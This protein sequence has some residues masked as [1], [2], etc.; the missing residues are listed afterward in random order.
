MKVKSKRPNTLLFALIFI[1]LQ[2]L[3]L[4]HGFDCIEAAESTI[5]NDD[6]ILELL[7]QQQDPSVSIECL[8]SLIR[9]N[10]FKSVNYVIDT[11][12]P[13]KVDEAIG[14]ARE[15]SAKV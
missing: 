1:I 12:E 2:A 5:R 15:A 11:L 7:K 13:E 6:Q 14:A 8:G 4:C 10:H 3:P 9:G